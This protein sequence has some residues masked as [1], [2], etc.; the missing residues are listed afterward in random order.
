MSVAMRPANL[1]KIALLAR[2][3]STSFEEV[4]K[5]Y[6]REYQLVLD[7]ENESRA[8]PSDAKHIDRTRHALRV[9]E[10]SCLEHVAKLE[11]AVQLIIKEMPQFAKMTKYFVVRT[12]G[13]RTLY[14]LERNMDWPAFAQECRDLEIEA[15]H[16][17]SLLPVSRGEDLCVATAL[18]Q[19]GD[20]LHGHGISVGYWPEARSNLTDLIATLRLVN[21]THVSLD[22]PF[23]SIDQVRLHVKDKHDAIALICNRLH[24]R[25]DPTPILNWMQRTGDLNDIEPI[26]KRQLPR[27]NTTA[28]R[29]ADFIDANPGSGGKQIAD[30]IG[31]TFEHFRKAIVPRLKIHGYTNPRN[32]DGYF[33]P[34]S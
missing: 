10:D 18:R 6:R 7:L 2:V 32:G 19:A 34:N 33:P 29:A 27:L 31:I 25:I 16:H 14:H 28:Q 11:E 23:T 22:A 30:E 15:L 13:G 1:D 17:A 21:P 3:L 12:F 24:P 26:P 9:Y 8:Y 20:Y 5:H 4:A